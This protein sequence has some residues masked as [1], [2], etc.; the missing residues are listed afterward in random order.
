MNL[1]MKWKKMTGEDRLIAVN[2]VAVLMALIVLAED[3]ISKT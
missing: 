1:R 2:V 3:F